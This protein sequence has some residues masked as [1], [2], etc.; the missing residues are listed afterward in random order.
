MTPASGA[1]SAHHIAE[2]AARHT[3]HREEAHH[4][5]RAAGRTAGVEDPG[6]RRTVEGEVV[7]ADSRH[8]AVAEAGAAGNRRGE[9]IGRA[10]VAAAGSPRRA[11]AEAEAAGSRLAGEDTGRAA[12]DTGQ[13]EEAGTAGHSPEVVLRWRLGGFAMG[14]NGRLTA[15]SLV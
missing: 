4:T 7:A 3:E 5:A 10:G 1:L 13:A 14:E 12:G 15:V 2:R 9:G 6:E 11:V 8:R